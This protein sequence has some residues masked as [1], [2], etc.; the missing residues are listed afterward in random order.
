MSYTYFLL[1]RPLYH[2]F[3]DLGQSHIVGPGLTEFRID[4][5]AFGQSELTCFLEN[6]KF[7]KWI[8]YLRGGSYDVAAYCAG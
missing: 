7:R 5:M 3:T 6:L 1:W 2:L 4:R 8:Q